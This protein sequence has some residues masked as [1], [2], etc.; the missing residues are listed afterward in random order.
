[1]AR[2]AVARLIQVEASIDGQHLATYKADGVIV[3]TATGS[4]GYSLAA[5]GPILYP[6][7]ED[8]LLVPIAP[9]LSSAYALVLPAKTIVE[10]RVK[11]IL[12]ATLSI[13][14][15]VNLPLSGGAII[16]VKR[17]AKTTRFLR[18]HPENSF[19]RSLEEKLK[20][21]R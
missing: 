15:H 8:F 10:L 19:Y 12:E 21:K 17:S 16:R 5:G 4:T 3:A 1:V 9:H 13:D 7:S 2:G 18:I 11:A 14:G 6:Q 20:G